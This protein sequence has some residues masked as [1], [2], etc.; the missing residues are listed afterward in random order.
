[1]QLIGFTNF[2]LL[3]FELLK[4]QA[5]LF[6]YRKSLKFPETLK[7]WQDG[8]FCIRVPDAAADV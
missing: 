8:A 2:S 4:T 6:P 5:E 1:M 3:F 7:Q